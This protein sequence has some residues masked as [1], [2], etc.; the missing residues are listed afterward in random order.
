MQR[1]L[2]KLEEI[3]PNELTI[4]VDTPPRLFDKPGANRAKQMDLN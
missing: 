1:S 3:P 2:S 4:M